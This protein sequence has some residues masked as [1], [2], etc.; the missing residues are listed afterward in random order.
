M[1]P[2]SEIVNFPFELINGYYQYPKALEEEM[3]DYMSELIRMAVP[4][5]EIFRP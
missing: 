5:A 4:K 1:M 3:E 2:D